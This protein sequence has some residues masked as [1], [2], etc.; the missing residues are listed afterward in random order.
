MTRLSAWIGV[1]AT[2]LLV[3]ARVRVAA[4]EPVDTSMPGVTAELATLASDRGVTRVGV[5]LKNGSDK[6]ARSSPIDFGKIVLVDAGAKRK[7]FPLKDADGHFLGGPISDWNGGGRWFPDLPPGSETLLWT[8]FD[9]LPAGSRVTLQ[10]P[11]LASFDD[12]TVGELG[13]PGTSVPSTAPPVTATLRSAKRSPG[14]LKV[15]LLLANPGAAKVSSGAVVYADVYAFDPQGKRKYPLL[16]GDDGQYLVSTASDNN[17]GGRLWL[18]D[19]APGGQL[20]LT[21]TFQAPPDSVSVVDVVIPQFAPL[22]AIPI[23]GQGGEKG[24]GIGVAGRSEALQRAL[25]DLNAKET[26]QT[27]TL[28]LSADVLFDFGKATLKPAATESLAK[29]ALVLKGYPKGRITVEGHT[30]GKGDDA[31]NQALSERRAKTVADWLTANAGV[32]S[33]RISARGYGKSRPVAPNTKPDGSDDPVGRARN[34]RVE[35]VVEK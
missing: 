15:Q 3:C 2:L 35:I 5:V 9:P 1:L 6:P 22:V 25:E 30:D 10:V 26:Q 27:V 21:M 17:Q 8:L 23:T 14:E 12:V 20:P 18:A 33:S 7:L 34:R 11:T 29:L 13:A 16:K 32:A 19:V 4:A 31:Y 24:G 28:Q